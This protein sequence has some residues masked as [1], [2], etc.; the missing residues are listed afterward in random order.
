MR[1]QLHEIKVGMPAIILAINK[2]VESN[3]KEMKR[4]ESMG[5]I[6]GVKISVLTKGEGP[7]VVAVG[8][9]R[10]IIEPDVAA[11]ILVA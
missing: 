10:V 1:K 6:P 3:C 5:I 8:D 4:L 11:N 9:S 2:N 7:M